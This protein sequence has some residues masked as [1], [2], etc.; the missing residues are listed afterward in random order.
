MG[1]RPNEMDLNALL[2]SMNNASVPQCQQLNEALL[3]GVQH[4]TNLP[5]EGLHLGIQ[6]PPGYTHDQVRYTHDQVGNTHDQVGYT[7]D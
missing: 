4:M 7:H 3:N 5:H 1:A 2:L 6:A